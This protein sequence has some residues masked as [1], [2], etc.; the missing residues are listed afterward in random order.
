MHLTRECRARISGYEGTIYWLVVVAMEGA[1][2]VESVAAGKG[3]VATAQ[4]AP[5][6]LIYAEHPLLRVRSVTSA[7][8]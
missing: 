6:D 7:P 2:A 1:V 4:L 3:V 8:R 5:K